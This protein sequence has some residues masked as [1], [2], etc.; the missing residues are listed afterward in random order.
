MGEPRGNG[1]LLPPTRGVQNP[2]Y[3]G[4]DLAVTKYFANRECRM[5]T[6]LPFEVLSDNGCIYTTI[7]RGSHTRLE[8]ELAAL[9]ITF[10]HGKPYHPTT[11]GKVER[12]HQTLK[13]WLKGQ[14]GVATIADLQ[15]QVDWF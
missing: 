4:D 14:P 13:K 8:I 12:F 10:K 1:P 5:E 15:A 7:Y 2:L 11:Q 6:R 9:H 3:C